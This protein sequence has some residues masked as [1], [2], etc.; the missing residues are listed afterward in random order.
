MCAAHIRRLAASPLA[1][2]EVS[3][4][5]APLVHV[6]VLVVSIRREERATRWGT[7]T[8][9]EREGLLSQRPADEQESGPIH[10]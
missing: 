4:E 5:D 9:L 2:D 8:P 1:E 3:L 10:A 7:E 6:T